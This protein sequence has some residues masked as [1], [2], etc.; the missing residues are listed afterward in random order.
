[1][2]AQKTAIAMVSVAFTLGLTTQ[3]AAQTKCTTNSVPLQCNGLFTPNGINSVALLKIVAKDPAPQNPVG[4]NVTAQVCDFG[5]LD[6][7][8]S[9]EIMRTAAPIDIVR[10]TT[11][12]GSSTGCSATPV[13]KSAT[14]GS[15]TTFLVIHGTGIDQARFEVR[16]P[17]WENLTVQ[18]LD[19]FSATVVVPSGTGCP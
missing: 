19:T 12:A 6:D 10:C 7:V 15:D 8:F 9:I 3:A 18:R 14:A 11:A 1:M 5:T 4:Q 17:G 2:T 16:A 13:A